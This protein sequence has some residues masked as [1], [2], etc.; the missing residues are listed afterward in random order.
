MNQWN[1]SGHI[2]LF[3]YEDPEIPPPEQI[4]CLS[5]VETVY[6]DQKDGDLSWISWFPCMRE[7]RI[8]VTKSEL[9]VQCPGS[10]LRVLWLF[11]RKMET[12]QIVPPF[13]RGLKFLHE[14]HL[15][16][17]FSILEIPDWFDELPN[18]RA[19]SLSNSRIKSI[20]KSLVDKHLPFLTEYDAWK[21]S[22]YTQGYID[23][24]GVTLEEGSLRLFSQP[25]QVI[26][27]YFSGKSVE[28][29]ECKVI[30]L[31]DGEVGKS[32]LIERITRD[33]FYADRLPTNGVQMTRWET[34]VQ[35][36]PFVLRFLDFGG[37]EI[38]FSM[39]RCFLT[40]HTVYVIVCDC[41]DDSEL[42]AA[43]QRWL[44]SLKTFAPDCPVI[45]ALNKAD[46]NESASVNEYYLR[47]LNPFLRNVLKTSALLPYESGV[48]ELLSAITACVPECVN[49]F[50]VNTNIMG[51]KRE[52][53]QM[54]E[55]YITSND[56]R[57]MCERHHISNVS[58]QRELLNWFKDTGVA[59]YYSST[60]EDSTGIESVH[61]LNPAWLTNGIYRLILRTPN[62]GILTHR[63][64]FHALRTGAEGDTKREKVYTPNESR[65]LL[66]VMR[67]FEISYPV[68]IGK[69][70]IP[71]KLNKTP[72][73]A[74]DD[75][76]VNEALHLRWISEYLPN[77]LIHRLMIRK[78][79]EINMSCLW[80]TGAWFSKN[81]YDLLAQL[82]NNH[83]DLYARGGE[84][85]YQ[86]HLVKRTH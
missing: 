55:D 36:S 15:H 35:D 60:K 67:N 57:A 73:S 11:F 14:L 62:S 22:L 27:S 84:Y 18:L 40:P 31:G 58:V 8:Y 79:A 34:T 48:R 6:A 30:F 61:V 69:E 41:R 71:M 20:P 80:R 63:T 51:L 23:L 56:Y 53:E 44:A 37:Q 49:A 81:R 13:V 52:L 32:S 24:R 28:V 70:F 46:L 42:D 1:Q 33:R 82:Q 72:P 54:Q 74:I 65:F 47:C 12:T 68:G 78:F 86:C 9:S 45:L 7:L 21:E 5:H 43:A 76:P 66:Y 2:T 85:L 25:R 16:S 59:Y 26:E 39:H 17:P 10:S 50:H 29:Q 19:I 4:Q 83:L 64:I 77:N 38:M 3:Q 75:F